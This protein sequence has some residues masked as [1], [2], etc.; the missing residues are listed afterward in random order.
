MAS[1]SQINFANAIGYIDKVKVGVPLP[2]AAKQTTSIPSVGHR[3][4]VLPPMPLLLLTLVLLLL[5]PCKL[6]ILLPFLFSSCIAGGL[7]V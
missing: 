3:M 6:G 4:V 2:V 1:E 7:L 5:F